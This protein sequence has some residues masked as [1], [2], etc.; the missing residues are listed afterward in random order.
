MQKR[1]VF[2][3]GENFIEVGKTYPPHPL[4]KEPQRF[5]N[6][7]ELQDKRKQDL[8]VEFEK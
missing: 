3:H 5:M 8:I 7:K 1:G 6:K 2:V 4:S